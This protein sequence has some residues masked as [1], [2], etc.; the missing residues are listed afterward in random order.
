MGG[1]GRLG[2]MCGE[3]GGRLEEKLMH[4]H[5]VEEPG[6]EGQAT[7][8]SI[9]PSL[10]LGPHPQSSQPRKMEVLAKASQPAPVRLS[11]SSSALRNSCPL[12]MGTN[13]ARSEFSSSSPFG[14]ENKDTGSCQNDSQNPQRNEKKIGLTVSNV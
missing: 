1:G 14:V 4:T 6:L 13:G 11:S 5:P 9:Y 2:S 12:G 3:S 10:M 7:T 8:L